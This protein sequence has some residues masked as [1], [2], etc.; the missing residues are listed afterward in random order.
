MIYELI[1]KRKP[2]SVDE[3]E[4]SKDEIVLKDF[5]EN[6]KKEADFRRSIGVAKG[7][8]ENS[9]LFEAYYLAQRPKMFGDKQWEIT[10]KVWVELL[11]Y[12]ATRCSPRSHL[13]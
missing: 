10:G 2:K 6:V 12:V 7:D 11:S 3:N 5:C 9:V 8:I 13:A 1:L 4:V